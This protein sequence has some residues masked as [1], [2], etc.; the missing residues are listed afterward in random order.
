M[1]LW[2]YV[3]TNLVKGWALVAVV[4]TTIFGL[5]FFIQELDHAGDGYGALEIGL[6]VIV[7]SPQQ[8]INLAPVIVLLGSVIALAQLDTSNELGTIV[9]A[10]VSKLQLIVIVGIP[11]LLLMIL[12]WGLME[13]VTPPLQTE[14]EEYRLAH[15]YGQQVS[16]ADGGVWSVSANRYLHVGQMDKGQNPGDVDL[17][18]FDGAGNLQ[19]AIHANT[20]VVESDGTWLLQKVVRKDLGGAGVIDSSRVAEL[21][22]PGLLKPQ[23][24]PNLNT[25]IGGMNLSTLYNYS[26]HRSIASLTGD[27][28]MREFWQRALMPFTVLAMALLAVPI[29]V[30]PGSNRSRSIGVRMSLGALVGILFYLGAQIVYSLGQLMAINYIVVASSPALIILLV[31]MYFLRRIRW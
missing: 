12:L 5:L 18:V 24:L 26:K 2:R 4:L 1:I 15:R 23:E 11:S 10:G 8:M 28:Y 9:C 7:S 20:A 31:A 13:F 27:D 19:R 6:Y 25:S 22:V 14:A 3:G 17:F 30:N 21:S 16:L 29:A